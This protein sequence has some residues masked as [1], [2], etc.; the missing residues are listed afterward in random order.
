MKMINVQAAKTH[1]SRL[2]ETAAAGQDILLGKHGRPMVRLTAYHPGKQPRRLGGLGGK[3]KI[4]ANFDAV[5]P[6]I[7]RLFS[8]E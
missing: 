6:R 1:L 8:G 7:Q 4:S 3:I 2:M 5:D